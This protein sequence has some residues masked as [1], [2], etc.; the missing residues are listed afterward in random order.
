[1]FGKKEL[2]IDIYK[3]KRISLIPPEYL[4]KNRRKYYYILIGIL[5]VLAVYAVFT[6]T[7]D[8]VVETKRLETETIEIQNKLN[9][10]RDVQLKKFILQRL[11]ETIAGKENLVT[12]VE[13]ENRSILEMINYTDSTLG[14]E[15]K[16]LAVDASADESFNINGTAESTVAIANFINALKNIEFDL[17]DETS[18]LDEYFNVVFVPNITTVLNEEDKNEY[19]FTI[20]C[21]FN[22]KTE[23]TTGG[24]Q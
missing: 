7:L 12:Q 14:E 2:S 4:K 19:S 20:T 17:K 8:I 22:L 3:D 16:Y 11:N 23:D 13:W 24:D 5:S 21:E 1:M 18:E 15:I 9:E 10:K 6:A